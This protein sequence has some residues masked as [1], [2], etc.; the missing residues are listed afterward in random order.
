MDVD[1]HANGK[2]HSSSKKPPGIQP[3]RWVLE[4]AREGESIEGAVHEADED[5]T[6]CCGKRV[7]SATANMVRVDEASAKNRFE[8]IRKDVSVGAVIRSRHLA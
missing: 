3:V 5:A 7:F 4:I 1:H 2:Q 8:R 6:N